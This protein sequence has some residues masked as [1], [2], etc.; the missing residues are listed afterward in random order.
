[1]ET[2]YIIFNTA[3]NK[4]GQQ[5]NVLIREELLDEVDVTKLLG[6]K[7]DNNFHNLKYKFEFTDKMCVRTFNPVYKL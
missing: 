3:Q 7:I 2:K 4:P 1:M 6:L 5:P